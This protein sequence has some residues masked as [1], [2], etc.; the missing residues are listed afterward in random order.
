MNEILVKKNLTPVTKLI[1][2]KNPF[3][4]AKAQPGQFVILRVRE[5]GER[6]PL[7]IADYDREKDTITLVFQEVGLST[8]LLGKLE[9]GDS[10]LN[11]VGPLGVPAELPESGTVVAVGGGVGVAPILPKCKELYK[12]GVKVIS[13]IGARSKDLIILEDEMR[14]CSHEVHICTDD[15]SRGF[16]GFV[17]DK[18]KELI[19]GG[20]KCDEVIAVG[21]IP[22][23]RATCETTRPYGLKTWVS[24]NPIMV[25]GTGMCGACRIT[26]G[27]KTRFVCVEGPMFDG[28]EV[29]W[30]EAWLRAGTYRAEEK[31][32]VESCQCGGGK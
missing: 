23:M 10:I 19:D 18:L 26:V 9:V 6:I 17:S 14:A 25:D 22:M 32:A 30:A 20:L 24:M 8:I 31:V 29:D 12:R 3:V 1:V 16:K 5:N 4:A 7:T 13:I 15:G 11:L 2:V 27:G 28:H 21:P